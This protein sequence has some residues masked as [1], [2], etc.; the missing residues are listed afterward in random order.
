MILHLSYPSE[1]YTEENNLTK[2]MYFTCLKLD[3][4]VIAAFSNCIFKVSLPVH[5]LLHKTNVS[6]WQLVII[7]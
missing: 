5:Y 1:L 4:I 7:Y 3:L 6:A 2:A